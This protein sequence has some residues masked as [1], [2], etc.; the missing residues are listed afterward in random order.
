MQHLRPKVSRSGSPN[1]I[2]SENRTRWIDAARAYGLI[3]VCLGHTL[4][5]GAGLENYIYSFHMPLFFFL[6]GY[7][8]RRESSEHWRDVMERAARRLL[9][10]YAVFGVLTFIPWVLITRH[11]GLDAG[12][13]VSPVKALFGIVVG[14]GV[15]GWLHH[16]AMLWFFP[17]LFVTQAMFSLIVAWV[18]KPAQSVVIVM[19]VAIGFALPLNLPF[20]LP[21]GIEAAMIAQ[22]FFGAGYWLRKKNHFLAVA[23][24]RATILILLAI[25]CHQVVIHAN[26][27][28]DM[29]YLSFG[30]PLLFLLG[31]A[32]GIATVVLLAVQIPVPGYFKRVAEAGVVIFPLHRM[33]YSVL[34]GMA[35][36]L[37]LDTAYKYTFAGSMAYAI[38]AIS[39]LIPVHWWLVVRLPWVVGGARKE[40]SS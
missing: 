26:G 21:W 3:L 40:F 18:P 4:G 34:T 11:Y 12:S 17:C 28:V 39:L 5:I 37:G 10:P 23:R 29:N 33:T 9:V 31:A 30:N 22:V 38:L 25:L 35:I 27:R 6:S 19:A 15:D 2:G 16:N 20:R 13:S 1:V 36:I 7:L 14:L 24:G 32:A 8:F